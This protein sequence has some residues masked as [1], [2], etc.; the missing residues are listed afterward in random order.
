MEQNKVKS[1]RLPFC[2]T[3]ILVKFNLIFSSLT[4]QNISRSPI[5]PF[6]HCRTVHL[7]DIICLTLLTQATN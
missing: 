4:K 6:S 3:I 1:Y 2:G 5:S 7:N